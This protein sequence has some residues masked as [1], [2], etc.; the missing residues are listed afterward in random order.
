MKHCY[1]I[2]V[3]HESSLFVLANG[4]I[5]HNSKHT[6]GKKGA[7][8]TYGGFDTINQL[9]QVPEAFKHKAPVSELDGRVEKIE[10]APQGGTYITVNGKR[11]YADTGLAP[12]VKE[13]DEVEAGDQLSHGIMNPADVVRLKGLGAGRKYFAERLTKA[14]RDSKLSINRRNAEVVARGLVDHVTVEAPEGVGDYLA[15]ETV[16]YSAVARS[17][18]PREGAKLEKPSAALGKFLEAPVL[19]HT[20]GTRIT[21]SMA[22]ELEEL[23]EDKVLTHDEAP[24]FEPHMVRAR[25]APQYDEDWMGQLQG[26]YLEQQ[27]LESARTGAESHLHGTNPYPALAAG[28]GFARGKPNEY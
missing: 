6:G 15:G 7:V 27:L 3:A 20:I 25:A 23:G 13:G 24:G 5:V 18:K 26:S 21:K 28:V 9:A 10:P 8:D 14:F 22:K 19:H 2:S 1:D 17:Y 12:L 11:H 4:L 16:P